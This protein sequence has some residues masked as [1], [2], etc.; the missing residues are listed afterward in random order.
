M[1]TISFTIENCRF[2]LKEVVGNLSGGADIYL[3]NSAVASDFDATSVVNVCC[4]SLG[5]RFSGGGTNSL[6]SLFANACVA[7]DHYVSNTGTE[8]G[9]CF[10]S[11]VLCRTIQN[12]V[13]S[14]N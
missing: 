14:G 6:D 10:D 11:A 3:N 12:C 9:N 13:S 7:D 1:N 4:D 2:L 5:V 8:G